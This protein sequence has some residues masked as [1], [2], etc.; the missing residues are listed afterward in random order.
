MSSLLMSLRKYSYIWRSAVKYLL[1]YMIILNDIWVYDYT[2]D[3]AVGTITKHRILR[4][5]LAWGDEWY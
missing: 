3:N 1:A 4:G 5:Q 2:I